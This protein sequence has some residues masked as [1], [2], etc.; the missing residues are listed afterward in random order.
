MKS[1]FFLILSIVILATAC[2]PVARETEDGVAGF[3]FISK[4]TMQGNVNLKVLCAIGNSARRFERFDI[5]EQGTDIIVHVISISEFNA[6]GGT[7]ISYVEESLELT[8][9]AAQ[10][11]TIQAAPGY[12][13]GGGDNT[14]E[15]TLTVNMF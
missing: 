15:E 10:T 7:V 5:E 8:G 12:F 6:V 9:L 4:D 13:W 1:I 3:R 11:Y 14:W 2:N